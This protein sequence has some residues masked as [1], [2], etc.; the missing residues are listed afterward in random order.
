MKQVQIGKEALELFVKQLHT[1]GES[2]S[3]VI[4]VKSKKTGTDFTYHIIA[5]DKN[6]SRYIS[7]AIESKYMTFTKV[8]YYIDNYKQLHTRNKDE[9]IIKGAVWVLDT[10][11]SKDIDKLMSLVD[12]YNTGKCIKCNRTLT[13]MDS[14]KFGMGKMCRTR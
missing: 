1:K 3:A 8:Y 2:V 4:V 14:I 7:I 12:V 11:Y 5:K 6:R 13:D 10:L 9:K